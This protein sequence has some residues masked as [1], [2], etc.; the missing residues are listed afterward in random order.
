MSKMLQYISQI[1]WSVVECLFERI[2]LDMLALLEFSFCKLQEKK[3][4]K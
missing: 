1:L 2:F 4:V 3:E